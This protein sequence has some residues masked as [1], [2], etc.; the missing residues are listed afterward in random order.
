MSTNTLRNKGFSHHFLLPLLAILGVAGVGF[1]M[2]SIGSAAT[3][4]ASGRKALRAADFID[5][6]GVVAHLDDET[7]NDK[8][9]VLRS[10]QYVGIHNVRSN[11]SGSGPVREWLA[12]N[13]IS[14]NYSTTTPKNQPLS[15]HLGD[16][17]N[18][19]DK[20]VVNLLTQPSSGA[21]YAKTTASV[22]LFNEYDNKPDKDPHWDDTIAYAQKKLWAAKPRLAAVNPDVKILGP[23]VTGFRAV[24]SAQKLKAKGLDK[25]M[26]YGNVH[27]YSGGEPPETTL[28]PGDGLDGFVVTDLP[29]NADGITERLQLYSSGIS[30]K[31]RVIVT[32]TGYHDYAQQPKNLHRYT[33]PRAVAVYM[34]RLYL[35]NFSIGVLRTYVYE[36]LDEK[37]NSKEYEKH[38]GLF[39]PAGASAPKA[40]AQAMHALNS[41]LS[42][43]AR[44]AD[45]FTTE[46][47]KYS[48][49][50]KPENVK[51]LLL[52]KKSGK[53]YLVIWKGE[54]VWEPGNGPGLGK[55]SAPNRPMTLKLTFDKNRSVSAYNNGDDKKTALGS[56]KTAYNISVSARPTILEIQ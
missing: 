52:Q 15:Q 18:A 53:F 21:K 34:P 47:L 27:S 49:K 16:V 29:K 2:L 5:S 12:K 11:S 43:D 55:Y 31:K 7:Y 8:N 51:T 17:D 36:L 40:S 9:S 20:R 32:E 42:D 56:G 38:F 24:E 48:I 41:V 19:I 23:S 1:Y 54:K 4:D 44:G 28:V 30:G 26:D 13:G 25:Y 10:L 50:D 6:Q 35:E 39:G 33:D 3:G 14:F 37:K 22:E 45:T 46:K